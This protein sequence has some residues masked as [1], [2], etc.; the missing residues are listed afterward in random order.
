MLSLEALQRRIARSVLDGNVMGLSA[1]VSAGRADAYSRLRIYRNNTISSLTT[2]LMAV[3]PVTARLVD[4]RYFR[5][6][7]AAFIRRHPPGE[8]RLVR[9]G[10][11]FPCF[12]RSFDGLTQ[13]PFVA[14][15][16]RLEWFIAEALDAPAQPSCPLSAIATAMDAA[17][18]ELQLQPSLRL[19]VANRPALSIWTA[20]QKPDDFDGSVLARTHSE[21]ICLWREG[22]IVRF[23]LHDAAEFAFRH[24]LANGQGLNRAATRALTHDPRFD[25]GSAILRLFQDGLV[26]A[27]T[28]EDDGQPT[29]G[30]L[31]HDRDD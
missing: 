17:S 19:F 25:L 9:Y 24:A 2:T 31:H 11:R 5:Y 23:R 29:T 7:A 22:E 14:E 16:A 10:E 1:L 3:F 12:L 6:V 18:P 30:D 28:E 15:T 13:M 26:T 27:V 4:E 8:P 21:R 20:H